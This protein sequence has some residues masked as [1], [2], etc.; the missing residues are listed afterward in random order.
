MR[1]YSVASFD[2]FAFSESGVEDTGGGL[3]GGEGEAAGVEEAGV[4]L[5]QGRV[6]AAVGCECTTS[7]ELFADLSDAVDHV[8]T[9]VTTPPIELMMDDGRRVRGEGRG[10]GGN[11][12]GGGRDE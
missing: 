4:G 3:L 12:E 8:S 2:H 11:S 7:D 10:G 9:R 5:G 6:E 1:K